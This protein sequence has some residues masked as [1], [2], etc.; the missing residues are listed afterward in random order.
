M[1]EMA[2]VGGA[3]LFAALQ[4]MGALSF[5]PEVTQREFDAKAVSNVAPALVSWL[6][7]LI[8]MLTCVGY[9]RLRWGVLWITDRRDPWARV[10]RALDPND[11]LFGA[12]LMGCLLVF[13]VFLV[14][15]TISPEHLGLAMSI[16]S[17]MGGLFIL[18]DR[19][20]LAVWGGSRKKTP[21]PS[22]PETS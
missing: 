17:L 5:L 19:L 10:P 3:T 11:S 22:R 12:L 6:T 18:A 14:V 7:A 15:V 21:E 16:A 8:V 1:M 13:S 4:I 20:L 2:W 9:L